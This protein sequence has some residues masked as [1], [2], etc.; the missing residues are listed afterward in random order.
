M[1]WC[2]CLI[3]TTNAFTVVQFPNYHFGQ[4]ERNRDRLSHQA[5]LAYIHTITE[6][7]IDFLVEYCRR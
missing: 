7:V 3:S 2:L 4:D 5:L 1:Y 6:T